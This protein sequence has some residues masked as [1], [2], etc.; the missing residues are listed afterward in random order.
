MCRSS[1]HPQGKRRCPA[2]SNPAKR[3]ASNAR[4]RERYHALKNSHSN[5]STVFIPMSE[6][7]LFSEENYDF[8]MNGECY[9][10]AHSLYTLGKEKGHDWKLVYITADIPDMERS[11]VH[12]SILTEKNELLD[13]DGLN[14]AHEIVYAKNSFLEERWGF[15]VQ[16]LCRRKTGQANYDAKPK[17]IVIDTDEHYQSLIKGQGQ[18]YIT[19]QHAND[20][21]K[22][23]MAWYE[24]Q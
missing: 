18:G 14:N 3:A 6:D 2:Q 11:W 17:M 12:M 22:H 16:D 7:E 15:D 8:Y 5:E 9:R 10:L 24:K 1:K 4:R 21:S 23:L 13:M 20:F 19:D